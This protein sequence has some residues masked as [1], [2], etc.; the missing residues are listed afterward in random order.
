MKGVKARELASPVLELCGSIAIALVIPIRG[1][2]SSQ[3]RDVLLVL[4]RAFMLY[5]PLK[6]MS[7]TCT[8]TYATLSRPASGSST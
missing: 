4:H 1:S 2:R 3:H 5:T 6:R 7:R 8:T